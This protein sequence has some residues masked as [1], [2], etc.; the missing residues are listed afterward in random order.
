MSQRSTGQ[1][2]GRRSDVDSD[3][4]RLVGLVLC[5]RVMAPGT[6]TAGL[7]PYDA[8]KAEP[9]YPTQMQ[10]VFPSPA[11]PLYQAPLAAPTVNVV[12][13]QPKPVVPEAYR[14]WKDGLCDCGNNCGNS[15]P[16]E[17]AHLDT[18]SGLDC[19]PF[20]PPM[21]GILT[22]LFYPCMVCHMYKL[23]G[24]CCCTPL[25]VPMADMVLSVKH[26][27]RHRIVGSVAGDCCTFVCCGPCA[28]CRLYRDMTFVEALKGSLQ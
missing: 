14:D 6:E 27:S 16:T 15:I 19:L 5:A 20:T 17:Y 26:R 28:L 21:G 3:A 1:P 23:Y 8:S 18:T 25:V 12:V 7:P 10:P 4:A 11:Q 24:E 2:T 13:E 22:A 9:I